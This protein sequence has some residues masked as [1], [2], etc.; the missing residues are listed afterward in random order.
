MITTN[1]V[2]DILG[3]NTTGID[4]D[5]L[6]F[7]EML[8]DQGLDSLDLISTLFIVED[9]YNFKILEEDI[10]LGSLSSINAIVEY[11]NKHAK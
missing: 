8:K 4:V 1:E 3:E 7:S 6:D 11:V 2:L 5:K 10:E 9:R